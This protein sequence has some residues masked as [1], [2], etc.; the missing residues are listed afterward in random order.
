V[1]EPDFRF[2][3]ERLDR[4]QAEMRDTRAEMREL[5]TL[6]SEIPDLVARVARL[7]AS[8]AARFEAVNDRFDRLEARME[9][10][11]TVVDLE[12]KQVHQTM[13]TNLAIVLEAIK[14]VTPG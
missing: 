6:K 7:E 4:L 12:F 2:I 13:A 9:V 1:A 14:G 11:S 8:T 10:R 3:G 5:R